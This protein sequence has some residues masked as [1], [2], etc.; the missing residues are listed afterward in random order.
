[1][2]QN[3]PARLLQSDTLR[4]L[5]DWLREH[6]AFSG[7]GYQ[8]SVSLCEWILDEMAALYP[9]RDTL[10]RQI[11]RFRQ[12]LPDSLAFLPR[13][14]RHMRDMA[15]QFHAE[16]SAFALLYAQKAWD[17]HSEEY[18]FMEK[19]LYRIWRVPKRKGNS[20]QGGKSLKKRKMPLQAFSFP[21]YVI[22]AYCSFP[23]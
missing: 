10:Q 14:Q 13:L 23:L 19:K 6:T 22:P 17:Y 2:N 16:E 1:M 11:R 8:E 21:E 7:Y 4:I 20:E 15:R 9:K 12:C 18:R 5:F 3:T